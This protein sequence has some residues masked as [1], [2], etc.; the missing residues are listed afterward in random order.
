MIWLL[1]GLGGYDPATFEYELVSG[2]VG[3]DTV[4][5]SGMVRNLPDVE[6]VTDLLRDQVMRMQKARA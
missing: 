1:I 3:L 4:S 5:F 2:R 6:R